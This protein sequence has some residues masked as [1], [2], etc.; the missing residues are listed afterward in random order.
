MH[1]PSR[2]FRVFHR[3]SSQWDVP[4][5]PSKGGVQE[6]SWSDEAP[7]WLKDQRLCTKLPLHEGALHHISKVELDPT[8]EVHFSSLYPGSGSFWHDLNLRTSGENWNVDRPVNSKLYLLTQLFLHHNW[9]ET[10]PLA[11]S[12]SHCDTFTRPMLGTCR[13]NHPD[14]N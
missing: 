9:L 2:E 3:A 7:S 5:K 12:W 6:V 1:I 8:N 11:P 10:T 13:C 4:I 14:S